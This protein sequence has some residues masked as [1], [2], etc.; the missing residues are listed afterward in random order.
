VKAMASRPQ[1]TASER[2]AAIVRDMC[3][4]LAAMRRAIWSD[5]MDE[6]RATAGVFVGMDDQ[7]V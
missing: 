1:S 7:D 4:W 2:A 5:G 6:C 3:L